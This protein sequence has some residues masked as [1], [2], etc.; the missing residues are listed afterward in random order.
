MKT[1]YRIRSI[2]VRSCSGMKRGD[3]A[4]LHQEP[5]DKTKKYTFAHGS[6]R[7]WRCGAHRQALDFATLKEAKKRLRCAAVHFTI[8]HAEVNGDAA[9]TRIEVVRVELG[10]FDE[11]TF[12]GYHHFCVKSQEVVLI[13][14][15]PPI[16][17]RLANI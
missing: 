4:Y 12:S 17:D 6:T 14:P 7:C 10:D 2:C 1:V 5:W 16:L 3:Y 9:Q 11:F 15:K 8:K 13:K